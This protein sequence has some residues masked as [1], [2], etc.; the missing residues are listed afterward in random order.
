M[1]V[2]R[3]NNQRRRLSSSERH[4]NGLAKMLLV[5]VSISI[6]CNSI[7]L[8]E[9]MHRKVYSRKNESLTEIEAIRNF[10]VVFNC[11]V[12][13][14]IYCFMAGKFQQVFLDLWPQWI[15]ERLCCCCPESEKRRSWNR[16][17]FSGMSWLRYQQNYLNVLL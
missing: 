15:R 3:A 7:Q 16:T 11:S 6:F 9:V 10:I 14:V 17:D 4:E 1:Q 12:N 13:F 5:V 2:R 8:F